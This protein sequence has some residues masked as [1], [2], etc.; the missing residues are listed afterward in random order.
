M[1]KVVLV[2][3]VTCSLLLPQSLVFAAE[4]S[5]STT[6]S[7]SSEQMKL[8]IAAGEVTAPGSVTPD[9]TKAKFSKEDAV[10]K[11]KLLFPILQDTTTPTI[12]LGNNH[13]Y[14]LPENQMVWDIQWSYQDGTSYHH[15]STSVDA[16]TGDLINVY[17]SLPNNN[18]N[19]AY[20]PP[21]L[22]K[23]E[24]LIEA[25]AFIAKAAPSI[26]IK[27][28][29]LE[30]FNSS[31]ESRAL[32]GP[33]QYSFYFT[34]LKNG[35]PTQAESISVA[36]DAN[37][38][39]VQFSKPSDNLTYPT[40]IA[41]ITQIKADKQFN[42]DLD[43]GLYYI[44]I[45]MNGRTT[46]WILGYRP[47]DYSTYAID[48]I[49]G[50]RISYEGTNVSP[51]P[52][53]YSDIPQTKDRFQPRNMKDQL[54][55]EE[56]TKLVQAVAI[57]P[58]DHV[59]QN[60]YLHS[61]YSNAE[62]QLWTL[63][64]GSNNSNNGFYA[65]TY[66]DIDADTG[67]ITQF[68]NS[69]F[70]TS[71]SKKDVTPPPGL[72]K[73]TKESA[74]QK[75]IN[76]IN[77]LYPNASTELKLINH[78]DAWSKVSNHYRYEFQRFYKGTPVS[79]IITITFD[80]YGRLQSYNP[81]RSTGLENIKETPAITVTKTEAL[82]AYRKQYSNMKLQYSTYGGPYYSSSADSKREIRLVYTPTPSDISTSSQVLDAVTGKWVTPFEGLGQ[83][84]SSIVPTDIKGHSAEKALS[85]LV[86]YGIISPDSEGK[87]SP[88]QVVTEGEWLSMMVKSI[89]PYYQSYY[90]GVEQKVV[91]GIE[92]DNSFYNVVNYAVDSK[93]IEKNTTF[94]PTKELTREQLA[95]ML[96]SIVN[97]S[98]LATYLGEDT[99][100]NQLSDAA[101]ITNKGVVVLALRLGLME[102]ENGAFH[103]QQKV[104]KAQ[105]ASTLMKLVEIQGKTDSTIG[106]R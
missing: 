74:K 98:K 56:A 83:R 47:V 23:E 15:F 104:T 95:V 90:S 40:S 66:A 89:A 16:M 39:I 48:A 12:T 84:V 87:L 58:A 34:T 94:Q 93:W 96:S 30:D 13:S 37:G 51:T 31:L 5:T 32:F 68:Q 71:G 97:Y 33:L 100:I 19:I 64:W 3:A 44:P 59:V 80:N 76:L 1:V 86:E 53:T 88:D 63:N 75:A 11:I 10:K 41:K 79:E 65:H 8:A 101:A 105:A 85:T 92:P 6:V 91:A 22:S 81:N 70:E 61:S 18:E 21:K 52:I 42:D 55:A 24:A 54:T 43:V 60:S 9:P 28:L 14:P 82:E 50:K 69:N 45:Q 99:S 77:K 57:L 36:I 67:E 29:H 2:S 103:P 35:I 4:G 17:I 26:S 49:T 102:S 106:Q 62:Q 46:D 72:T 73:L 27:D 78:E 7:L 25:K 20:Y 38:N